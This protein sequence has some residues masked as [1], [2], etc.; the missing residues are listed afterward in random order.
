MVS[1]ELINFCPFM[2]GST[3]LIAARGV[4]G[5]DAETKS[6]CS[7]MTIAP[8][9]L[10]QPSIQRY[11]G[12]RLPW[13]WRFAPGL[14]WVASGGQACKPGPKLYGFVPS[15][16]LG[17]E[18]AS[19]NLRTGCAATLDVWWNRDSSSRGR[20]LDYLISRRTI[21]DWLRLSDCPTDSAARSQH[22]N[23]S[24]S[25]AATRHQRVLH[26]L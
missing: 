25:A 17:W 16:S 10:L 23:K 20:M 4:T 15:T 9:V 21:S 11:C 7:Q 3:E 19:V 8:R 6:W 2:H 24:E 22:Q 14:G 26:Q 1:V 12:W 5:A 13:F 18:F